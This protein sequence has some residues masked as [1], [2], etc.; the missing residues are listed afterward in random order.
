[1]LKS[2]LITLLN[3]LSGDPEILTPIKDQG[4]GSKYMLYPNIVIE[5]A[6]GKAPGLPPY[7]NASAGD[8]GSVSVYI[9]DCFWSVV[10]D[11]TERTRQI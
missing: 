2:E 4:Y 9:L 7:T 11:Y 8:D 3:T 10:Y 6:D 5:D 1:M